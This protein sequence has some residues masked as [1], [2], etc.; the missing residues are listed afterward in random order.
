MDKQGLAEHLNAQQTVFAVRKYH[1][2]WCAG[3][4]SEILATIKG[5]G[6]V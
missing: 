5:L 1:S 6:R 3:T 4:V 2:H